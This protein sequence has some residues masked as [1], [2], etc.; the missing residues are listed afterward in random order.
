[1]RRGGS[2]LP[3]AAAAGTEA[4]LDERDQEDDRPATARITCGTAA[5][6]AAGP[7]AECICAPNTPAA[8]MSTPCYS[9]YADCHYL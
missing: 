8:G 5:C 4:E 9:W 3:G 2:G 1:L 6:K 7:N